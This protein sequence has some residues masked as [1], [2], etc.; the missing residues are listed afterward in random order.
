MWKIYQLVLVS[1]QDLTAVHRHFFINKQCYVPSVDLISILCINCTIKALAFEQR[2]AI[3][4]N[5]L[6][7]AIFPTVQTN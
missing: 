1:N 5:N 4:E 7:L 3:H 6:S 2:K